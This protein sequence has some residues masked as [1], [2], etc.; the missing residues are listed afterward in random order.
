MGAS[1][2][3][4]RPA[5]L[6]TTV[7]LSLAT[8]AQHP[9][10][11]AV[12]Q[13][14]SSP[15]YRVASQFL[16]RDYDRFVDELITLTE[17]PAPPFGEDARALRFMELA[18][19]SG[20]H[21]VE[22]DAEGNVL[23]LR[24]GHGAG[25]LAVAAHLDTVFP[26][27][28]DVTVQRDGTVL[29]APGIGDNSQGVAAMLA[30]ARAMDYA[31][32][33]TTASILFVGTVGEEG[34]GSLRGVRHLLGDGHY[35][36]RITSFIAIDGMGNGRFVTTGGVGSLRYRVTFSGPGGH[37]YG[38]FGLVNPATALG[39]AVQHLA[40]V[41]VPTSP[42]TTFN[43]GMIGG[44]TSVNT[45]PSSA[46]MD[47]DLRSESPVELHNLDVAFRAAIDKAVDEENRARST[48]QGS[49][50]ATIELLGERPSGETPVDRAIVQIAS[51]AIRA[52]GVQPTYGWSSTDANLPMSLGI[53][54]ITI[55][56][57]IRG[58]RAHAP[59]EWIDVH[60]A[61]VVEGLRRVLLIVMSVAN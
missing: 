53:P 42:R 29:R 56:T 28:T 34:P 39:A 17:V 6:A 10:D 7:A 57:G 1:M 21:Q 35:A 40:A 48:S 51:S 55:D 4:F 32:A 59:D 38:A 60:R 25:I 47:V 43:V 50:N 5:M 44:G 11:L 14:A 13:M 8:N 22:R 16:D 18:R 61:S 3:L 30:L 45:I 27:G 15:A 49:I 23:I 9:S 46:W 58:G 12:Q 26:E 41:P 2:P 36:K 20:L 33:Q 19:A 54:A 37:S 31:M 24:P 52:T